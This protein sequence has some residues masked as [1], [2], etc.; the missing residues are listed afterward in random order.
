MRFELRQTEHTGIGVG[1]I[2][3]TV[4]KRREDEGDGCDRKDPIILGGNGGRHLEFE[5][6]KELW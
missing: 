2:V 6:L 1:D 3:G 5:R 4:T